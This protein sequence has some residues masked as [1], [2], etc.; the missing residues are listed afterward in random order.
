MGE[1]IKTWD[2]E[3]AHHFFAFFIIIIIIIIIKG[4]SARFGSLS[5]ES[6]G[7]FCGVTGKGIYALGHEQTFL[8]CKTTP[9]RFVVIVARTSYA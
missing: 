1:R 4:G 7:L 8:T 5:I 9:P 2:P 3:E 6:L